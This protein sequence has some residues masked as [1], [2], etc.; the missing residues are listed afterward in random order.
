MTHIPE[1]KNYFILMLE[2]IL[3][4]LMSAFMW[5]FHKAESESA[6]FSGNADGLLYLPIYWHTGGEPHHAMQKAI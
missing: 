2:R 6:L 1:H 3:I 5:L 4:L